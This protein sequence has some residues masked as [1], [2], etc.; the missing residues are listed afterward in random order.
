MALFITVMG[1]LFLLTGIIFGIKQFGEYENHAIYLIGVYGITYG[2]F[3]Y[4]LSQLDGLYKY[5]S[6]IIFGLII[7][8][9]N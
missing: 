8:V 1:S 9:N 4:A 5:N 7:Q 3:M 6:M 2:I